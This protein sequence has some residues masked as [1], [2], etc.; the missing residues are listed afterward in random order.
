LYRFPV[1]FT[2]SLSDDLI[3]DIERGMC[4]VARQISSS[5]MVFYPNGKHPLN[6][7]QSCRV[8]KGS[9]LFSEELRNLE[10]RK[11]I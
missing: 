10:L 4:P 6:M 1:L 9:K 3:P 7:E 2:G 8:Q 11:F 5:K